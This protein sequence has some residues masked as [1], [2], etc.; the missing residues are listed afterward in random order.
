ME[1]LQLVTLNV[2]GMRSMLKRRALFKDLRDAKNDIVFL[3]ETHCTSVEEKIW[4]S[5]WGGPGYFSHGRSNARGVGILFAR[6][7]N[8]KLCEKITDDEGRLLILQFKRGDSIITLANLYAPTQGE[9]KEQDAFLD[10]LDQTLAN[11]EVHTLLLGGDLNVHLDKYDQNKGRR[12]AHVDAYVAKIK[13]LLEDYSLADVWK[14]KYPTNTRGT[15]HRG[16]YSARLDYWMIPSNMLPHASIKI[17]PHPLSDHCLVTIKIT[18]NEIKRGPGYWRFDNLLLTDPDFCNAMSD[19][20][21][22]AQLETLTNPNLQWEWVKYKVRD[23]CINYSINRNRE[24]KRQVKDLEDRL[25]TLALEHDLIGSP[26]IIEEVKSIKRELGEILQTKASA[27]VFRAKARWALQGEKPTAYFL[28]LEKRNSKN[29]TIT[30]LLDANGHTITDNKTILQ[31]EKEYFEDIYTEDPTKLDPLDLLPLNEEDIPIISELNRLRINRPFTDQEFHE[32][33]KDLNKNKTPGS[34]GITPEFYLAFWSQLKESFRESIEFSLDNGT[35][36]EQQRSGVITLVPKKD[37]DRQTLSNWRPIT[38]LNSDVKILSKALAKRIQSCITEVVSE[39]QTGFIRHRSIHSNLLTIQSLIDRSDENSTQGILL[40]LDYSK[41]FDTVRWKIIERA[42]HLFGF[43]D[44][45]SLVVNTLFKDIKTCVSNA[46]FSSD[47]FYPT[48]GIRQGCCASPVLF[49]LAVELMAILVRKT[50]SIKGFTVAKNDIKISQY[51]D[52]A[53]FFLRD[54]A[55]LHS[56]LHTLDLFSRLSGLKMN[57]K[58]SHLLLL[59]NY[60]DPPTAIRGITVAESVKILGIVYKSHMSREE[61]YSLNFAA[62]MQKIRNTCGNWINRNMSLKGKITLIGALLIS[63]LQYPCSCTFV[64]ERVLIEFKKIATEFLWSGKRSKVV[65]NL[66][67]QQ[68]EHGGLML[69]DLDTRIHAIHLGII[70]RIWHN[71]NSTW[72]AILAESLQARD[73]QQVILF[74]ADLVTRPPTCYQTFAQILRTWVKFHKFEPETE[75]EVQEELIWHNRD[76][77][78]ASSPISWNKWKNAGIIHINDLIHREEPRFASHLE[79]SAEYNLECSFLQLLQIRSAIPCKWKRL[80]LGARRQD[81]SP[82]PTIKLPD[83]SLLHVTEV[84]AKKVYRAILP[85]K[86][87]KIPS[88]SKWAE[89]YPMREEDQNKR[90][91]QTYVFPYQATR[92]TKLQSLQFRITHRTIPCNR[93]LR[94]IRIRQDDYCSFCDNPTPDTLQH[95]FFSC[96]RVTTFWCSL[97]SWLATQANF[98]LNITENH[99]MLGVPNTF[100]QAR[101]INLLVLLVKNFILRQKLFHNASLDLSHFLRELR[102]K[103]AVEKFIYTQGKRPD[104]FKQWSAIYKALG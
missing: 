49:V 60:K 66:M 79:L 46:G 93:Y 98:H 10:K 64:P 101:Y 91:K 9:A 82:K 53:T 48:G 25:K 41:A 5:E 7:F 27:T 61:Q 31:M 38:L 39:D 55:S 83:R 58:K 29:N 8:P 21:A 54:S 90:W 67:I 80:L 56:L 75:S 24:R 63:I 28:G 97:T 74:K 57:L 47:P 62:R 12:S 36:T 15:F 96:P 17:K 32:A 2:N 95:F 1:N 73:I 13:T 81:L 85:N 23:F 76:I 51:A 37:L 99:F 22:E 3:Q 52:D 18:L 42:L 77:N 92:E 26:D 6:N 78:I 71:P 59:G 50:D 69:P 72:A 100:P 11:I 86:L 40:A 84:T 102:Q 44:F 20:I 104:K 16:P 68:I 30:S 45:I 14:N 87:P 88:Q 70:K 4:L 65:Y 34:D 103:L 89:L 94:N 43:G 35:L 19:H 33:L